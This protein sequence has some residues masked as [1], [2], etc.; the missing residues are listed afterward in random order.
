MSTSEDPVLEKVNLS[1]HRV[2]KN[3]L[4]MV[5]VINL[6]TVCCAIFSMVFY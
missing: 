3:Q 2:D 6:L 1:R 4:L 5:S